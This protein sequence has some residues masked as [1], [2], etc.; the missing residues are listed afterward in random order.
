MTL[1]YL[2]KRMFAL[3][4]QSIS[5]VGAILV[6]MLTVTAIEVA[7][8]PSPVS[9]TVADQR[10]VTFGD[11]A[12]AALPPNQLITGMAELPDGKWIVSTTGGLVRLGANG[13]KDATYLGNYDTPNTGINS[14]VAAVAVDA[15]GG[16]I[17]TSTSVIR[18][19]NPDG[20]ADGNF[21]AAFSNPWNADATPTALRVLANGDIL[22]AGQ[23]DH[24]NVFG[25]AGLVR[26]TG[27]GVSVTAFNS[28][29]GSSWYGLGQNNIHIT[30]RANEFEIDSQ[31]RILLAAQTLTAISPLVRFA[32]NGTPD[33]AFNTAVASWLGTTSGG[34]GY[35]VEPLADGGYLFVGRAPNPGRWIKT[36]AGH[37]FGTMNCQWQ[38]LFRVEADGSSNAS[39]N[40]TVDADQNSPCVA[41][42]W[43]PTMVGGSLNAALRPGTFWADYYGGVNV[44]VNGDILIAGAFMDPNDSLRAESGMARFNS[45]GQFVSLVERGVANWTSWSVASPRR[46][47]RF[48]AQAANGDNIVALSEDPGVAPTYAAQIRRYAAA[49]ALPTVTA[50]SPSSGSA[51]GG[52]AITITGTNFASGATVTV[53]GAAC[54]NVVVVSPTSITCTTPAR[55]A[56]TSSVVVT[57]GGQS[58]AANSLFTFNALSTTT[59]TT[60]APAAGN[61]LNSAVSRLVNTSNQA[62]LTATPGKASVL[63]NGVAV[64]PQIVTASNS[65]AAQADPAQRSP[66]QVRELQQ[67]AA[68]IET[69]LDTIA[70]GDSGVSVVRTETGAVLT[71]IFSGTRVPVEDVVVVNAANT[72]TLFAARD[73]RGNIVEVKPGAV[74]EVASN[75][76]VAVQAFGLQAGENVELVVMSTPTLLGTFTVDA[77]G[78]IKTTAKLPT[79]IGSGNHSLVVASPSVKA[80]LGLKLVKSSATLPETGSTT[81]DAS[82]WAVAVT[83]SGIYLMMVARSRRRVMWQ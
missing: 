69:R 77:K 16:V 13:A 39:I 61:A 76:D 21:F 59:T 75:G 37:P 28:N 34:N 15:Q 11:N 41:N 53:G 27:A 42:Q 71:G 18:R 50:V 81:S 56:G 19:L 25:S 36:D 10:N 2:G 62:A 45:T 80:S 70:G 60:T 5:A 8:T 82:N 17:F 12:T 47:V 68:T 51:A 33:T 67:T 79:T 64:V 43:G 66:E 55:T 72:A 49:P 48:L 6:A 78:T 22:A 32:A 1:N 73:V 38:S 3:K 14:D 20:S 26:M 44:D 31:G 58:N 30:P 23:F 35:D 24:N 54:S 9:A 83:L 57:S 52:T 63:V 65:A 40:G 74:L 4:K 7:E 46:P 29:V